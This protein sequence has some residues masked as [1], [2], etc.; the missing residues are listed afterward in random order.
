MSDDDAGGESRYKRLWMEFEVEVVDEMAL[1]SFD[2]HP[3][4]DAQGN[5]TGLIDMD[6]DER[7]MW[8]LIQVATVA[9][10]DAE[11]STGIRFLGGSGPRVRMR[12]ENGAYAQFTI[13]PMPFRRDDGSWI[14][15]S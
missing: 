14:E 12:D 15:P 4:G 5:I 2:L 9:W 7:V 3:T 8:A 1:R 11:S 6:L 13:P 10:R